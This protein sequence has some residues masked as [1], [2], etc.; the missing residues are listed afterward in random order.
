M[1]CIVSEYHIRCAHIVR[2]M[3]RQIFYSRRTR[4]TRCTLRHAHAHTLSRTR[5]YFVTHTHTL[6]HAHAHTSPRTHCNTLQ[7]TATHCNT[8][9]KRT[10]HTSPTHPTHLT[11]HNIR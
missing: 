9:C 10:W 6:R 4:P 3:E 1:P 11:Q 8:A 7:H 5:T 2:C